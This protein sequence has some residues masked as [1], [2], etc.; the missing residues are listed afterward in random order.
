M[1]RAFLVFPGSILAAPPPSLVGWLG[2]KN[3]HVCIYSQCT[4][5]FILIMEMHKRI[6]NLTKMGLGDF[7]QTK[8]SPLVGGLRLTEGG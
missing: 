5:A 4:N 6:N 3:M 7:L 8:K 1:L 2:T